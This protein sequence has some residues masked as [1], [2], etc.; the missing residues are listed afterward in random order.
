MGPRSSDLFLR[1]QSDER[2]IALAR[3]GHARAFAVIVERYRREL[4]AHARR[5]RLGRVRPRTSSSR[6]SSAR[7]PRSAPAPTFG[8]CAPGCTRSFATP[9]PRMGRR[10]GSRA[11]HRRRP[12]SGTRD[13][14]TPRDTPPPRAL[15]PS[16]RSPSSPRASATRSWRPRCTAGAAR[17]WPRTMGLSE[18]AVRGLVHRARST[19][20]AGLTVL[21]P[22]PARAVALAR[23]RRHGFASRTGCGDNRAQ[24]LATVAGAGAAAGLGAGVRPAR[25]SRRP[26]R[27]SPAGRSRG[28]SSS[29]RRT[30]RAPHAELRVTWRRRGQAWRCVAGSARRSCGALRECPRSPLCRLRRTVRQG[31]VPPPAA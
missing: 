16:S 24:A 30:F 25:S 17:R 7:S 22:Y 31:T 9:R 13:R 27:S 29:V 4:L 19:L 20:R 8:I 14:T 11:R 23:A 26:A 28:R 3:A 21:L 10:S 15:P 5:L 18:R 12:G 1:S 6:R 2:L